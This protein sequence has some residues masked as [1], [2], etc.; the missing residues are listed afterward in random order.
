MT[1]EPSGT[2]LTVEADVKREDVKFLEKSL[3]E[4]NARTT[5]ISDIKA[6]AL[7]ARAPDGSPIAG[8]FGWT[9]GGTCH[10]RL[11]FVSE[12]MRGQGQGTMLMRAAEE[13]AKSRGCQQIV[14]ETHDFQAPAFYQKLGFKIVGR[15]NDYPRGSQ[16]LMLVKH[17]A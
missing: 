10:I 12:D 7:F 14:V 2:H 6:F 11:L 3:N 4:F 15:V 5:G 1:T 9:W 16:F 13:E 8:A 17:L